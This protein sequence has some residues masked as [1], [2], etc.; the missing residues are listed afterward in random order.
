MSGTVPCEV[1]M[2]SSA[3]RCSSR[4]ITVIVSSGHRRAAGT[5]VCTGNGGFRS[6]S[7][8]GGGKLWQTESLVRGA[9][10][11]AVTLRGLSGEKGFSHMVLAYAMLG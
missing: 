5:I 7:T 9:A 10:G 1:M 8:L 3:A 4:W 2:A 6:V 11:N